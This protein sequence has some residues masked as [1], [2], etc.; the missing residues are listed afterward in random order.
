[1]RN[2]TSRLTVLVLIVLSSFSALAQPQT[3][4]SVVLKSGK[5]TPPGNIRDIARSSE[6]FRVSRFGEKNYVVI[7]FSNL[8]TFEKR[9][10][11]K[12]AGITLLD[13]LPYNS[14]TASIDE[15]ADLS[16]L[17]SAGARSLFFLEPFQKTVSDIIIGNIPS[18]AIKEP[19]YADVN[20]LTYE[21]MAAP[22]V[23]GSL[24]AAGARIMEDL[25][26]FRMFTV[27]VP[28]GNL[29]QLVS[30][31]FVQWAEFIE[32]PN[33]P[34]NLP[35]RTLHRVNVLQDGVRNLKGDGMNVGI[36]DEVASQHLD[37]SPSGR[38]TNVEPG[39]A[40]S[41]GTHVSGT[42]GSRGLI[43][44]I[45][46]GMA[47]NANIYSY[48]GFNGDVQVEMAT[49]I[50]QWTLIS[51][52]HSY[53]DGLGV[54]C[55]LSGA[56]VSYSLRS[57]NTDINLNNNKYHIHCHSSGNAQSSCS[58]GWGTITGTGKSAKNNL[59]VG[60][61]TTTEALSS[62][63]SCGPVH[64]GRIKPEIVAMGTSVFSTYTPLNTYGTISGTSMSTPG[65]TGSVAILA[66]RYKQ[67]NAN[68]L[69]GSTLIK[70]IVCN[71]AIDLGTAGPDYRFGFGR[72]NALA[73]VRILEQNTYVLNTINTGGTQDVNIT[74]PAGTARLRVMLTWNDTAAAANAALALVNNLDLRVI[75]GASNTTLPWLLDP[76]NP[77]NPAFRA[78]DNI[79]NIEQVTIDNPAPGNYILRVI[80]EA[81]VLN[82]DQPYA[83]TWS[84]DQAGIEV[85]YP[86]GNEKFS[87]GNSEMITWNNA[88]VTG[89][90]TVEYSLDGTTN[91]TTIGTVA[92]NV[93]RLSWSVPAAN[94]STAKIRVT[95]GSFTDQSDE[96]FKIMSTVPGFSGNGS[97]C[98]AGEIIFNWT[99]AASATHYEIFRLD[100]VTGFFVSLA[101]NITGTTYTATGLTPGASMWFTIIA[102]NN[103]TGAES[104]K[105]VAINVVVSTGGG[106]IGT[107]GPISGQSTI[108]GVQ[109]NV[110]YSINAVT[111]ATSYTW[112]APPGAS[113]V[114]GQGSTNVAISYPGG[115][116]SGNVSVFASNG[117]CQ[118]APSNLAVTV[119]TTNINAPT[120]GGNQTQTVC[121][122]DPVPTL[123]A[124]ANVPGGFTVKWYNAASGGTV[125][126]NPTLSSPGTVTYYAASVET[127]TGCESATRTAVT[128]TINSIAQASASAGGATTFCQGG[129]VTLTANA[130]GTYLWSNGATTQSITVNASGSYTVTVTNSGCTSTS[131]PIN[132][133]VNSAPAANISAGGPL[134]FCQGGSV[135]LTASAGSSWVWSNG[136]TTQAITV[137]ATGNYSVVVTNANGCSATSAAT[138]VTVS[139]NPVVSITAAP[140]NSLY[141]GI[142][143]TLTAN[144]NPTGTYNYTWFLN[145]VAIPGANSPTL[146]G[147]DISKLGNYTVTVTNTSGLP[148]SNTSPAKAILDSAIAKLFILPNPNT[149]QFDVIYHSNGNNT[150]SLRIFD[151]KGALAYMRSYNITSAY[152][153]MNVD[154]R[155]HGKG[156]FH[157]VLSASGKRLANGKVIIQ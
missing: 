23:A 109:N 130:G 89:S 47:P 30:L 48:N 63:S 32:P 87:P 26:M 83:L 57:R 111:G 8:P 5:F 65:I 78:D 29:R 4:N 115:A 77:G 68:Q 42:V 22:A 92:A 76:V 134:A 45:A 151:S 121:Q 152:Q 114:S 99:A 157:I 36:W 49:A 119:N 37:F 137:S 142:S 11:L 44:P 153:R 1:M 107:V 31:P 58:G 144:V 104:E 140:Y 85:T 139:P 74:V 41:H 3:E 81:I 128:L 35:G 124:T 16:L 55:G 27:R 129:S 122:P 18:H 148:C 135:T 28:A 15:S 154:L 94:T 56:S 155:Q 62:S 61:I 66:Q 143:T 145:N 113:V 25:P 53:H 133:T 72:I 39:S 131:S 132:V 50:P 93:T 59:V 43:N 91:W 98:N 2:F 12:F 90:Q 116:S 75:D 106:G 6:I 108:C 51:S 84:V 69:P 117:S 146:T 14:Y 123:T 82:P 21:N 88:G 112:S 33:E 38:L 103:T 67:L 102:K 60:N 40:G 96:G 70:N 120:S 149:G 20:I 19:G 95:S 100:P 10:A 97:T 110:A 86:N 101:N 136:A 73:A 105:A 141:P 80:G 7:Q 54:Q 125:V 118:T 147:I 13:Y 138:A 24:L 150:Y 64:D 79:S 17:N 9:N 156:L 127:A 126:T 34:E 71:T 46:R 52:N